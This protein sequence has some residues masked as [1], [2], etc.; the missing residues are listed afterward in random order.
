MN[1]AGNYILSLFIYAWWWQ[2]LSQSL[3]QNKPP[4]SVFTSIPNKTKLKS[5]K[6]Q[7]RRYGTI[8]RKWKGIQ[9]LQ[10]KTKWTMST[11]GTRSKYIDCDRNACK[12]SLC[13]EIGK[14][15]HSSFSLRFFM[16]CTQNVPP[17]NGAR[18]YLTVWCE[19]N[20]YNDDLASFSLFTI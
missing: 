7:R 8:E 19:L 1:A 18:V 3:C 15:T 2:R 9:L 6:R 10:M 17:S 20:D 4:R 5:D 16:D 12:C 13:K 11:K 14:T